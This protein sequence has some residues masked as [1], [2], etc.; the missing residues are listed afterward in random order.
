MSMKEHSVVHE[1]LPLAAA[2]ALNPR[3]QQRVEKHLRQCETCR[4]ELTDWTGIAVALKELPTPQARPKMVLQTRRLLEIYAAAGND[5]C[6]SRFVPAVLVLF[7]WIAMFLTWRLVRLIDMPLTQWLD[8]S[9][10]TLW[11]AFIGVTWLAT[12]L[13]AGLLVKHSRQEEKFV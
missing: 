2:G 8:I 10:T 3:E 12:A 6:R 5:F 9:S 13:A 1:L 4:S 11:I 7:S